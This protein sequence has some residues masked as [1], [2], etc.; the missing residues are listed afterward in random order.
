MLRH[1]ILRS[2][3]T[4]IKGKVRDGSL[5]F[6]RRGK[7]RGVAGIDQKGFADRGNILSI[8]LGKNRL[9]KLS[10]PGRRDITIKGGGVTFYTIADFSMKNSISHG[11]K[12]LIPRA[13]EKAFLPSSSKYR[14]R[15]EDRAGVLRR[16][17]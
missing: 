8:E 10:M 3:Y 9:K 13:G 1:N 4:T 15:R 6:F 5:S 11:E 2:S 16:E 17:S 7:K 12:A 14:A